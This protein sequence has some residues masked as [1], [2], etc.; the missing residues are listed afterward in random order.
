MNRVEKIAALYSSLATNECLV[1]LQK[2]R[3]EL[4]ATT[5]REQLDDDEIRS[6][7]RIADDER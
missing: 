4:F 2:R 1:D 3:V 6:M 5:A 7:L